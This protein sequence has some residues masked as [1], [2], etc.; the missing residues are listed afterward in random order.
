MYIMSNI[1]QEMA[2]NSPPVPQPE[3][4]PEPTLE[5]LDVSYEQLK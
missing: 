3:I 2:R 4:I 1:Q 5:P